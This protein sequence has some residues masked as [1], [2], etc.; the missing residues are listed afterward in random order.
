MPTVSALM[1]AGDSLPEAGSGKDIEG[2]CEGAQRA[3]CHLL[4]IPC[5]KIN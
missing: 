3:Y 5:T 1:R 2:E 4:R